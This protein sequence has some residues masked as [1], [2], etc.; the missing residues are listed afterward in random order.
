MSLSSTLSSDDRNDVLAQVQELRL[1]I[2]AGEWREATSGVG[3]GVMQANVVI[4][5]KE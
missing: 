5:P 2:R 3:N 4:L 1:K